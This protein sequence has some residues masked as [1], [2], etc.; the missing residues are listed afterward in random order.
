MRRVARLERDD[1]FPSTLAKRRARLPRLARKLQE[2][3]PRYLLDQRDL[4]REAVRRHR[5]DVLR[6]RMRVLRRAEHVLR[7]KFAIDFVNFRE[8]EDR[9]PLAVVSRERDLASG[10]Q[11]L[12][13]CLIDAERDRN[14]PRH[15]R[16][17][18]HLVARASVIR[19]AHEAGQRRERARREHL[20]IRD[21]ASIE[22]DRC[23]L[24][25]M[26]RERSAL[27]GRRFQIDQLAA[28]V[29]R[30]CIFV[31]AHAH[32]RAPLLM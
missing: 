6:P 13:S 18:P 2:R 27:R 15:T 14:R 8:L 9:Q 12:R 17:K 19:L 22:R 25:R 16:R 28:A 31:V 10:L 1:L 23:E 30:D 4:A 21:V 32:R 3:A 24:R 26:R 20:E 5:G 11:R 7:F 29:R